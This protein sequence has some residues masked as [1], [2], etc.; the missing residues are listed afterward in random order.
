MVLAW[1]IVSVICQ[2]EDVFFEVSNILF[3]SWLLVLVQV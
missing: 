3:I 1:I 2:D